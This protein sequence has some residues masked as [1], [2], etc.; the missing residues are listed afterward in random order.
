MRC[1]VTTTA[2]ERSHPH[3]ATPR[4]A[5]A[6]SDAPMN[7]R[8]YRRSLAPAVPSAERRAP[9][10]VVYAGSPNAPLNSLALA[11]RSAGIF[12]SAFATA[13]VTFGGTDFRS[14][15]TAA[16]GSAMIFMMICCA[17]PPR[18]GGWPASIS[19]STL[20]SEYTSLRAVISFSAVACSGLM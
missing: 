12:S 10:P 6:I 18:C 3:T 1:R 9:S 16:T 14:V 11:K 5:V 8:L 15:V 19:K 13:A 2:G 7:A 20:P 4:S 17:E